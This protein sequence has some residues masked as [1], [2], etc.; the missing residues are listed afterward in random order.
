MY[1]LHDFVQHLLKG[2]LNSLAPFLLLLFF[3]SGLLG[4]I[5]WQL[6]QCL[7]YHPFLTA[8]LCIPVLELRYNKIKK[9][10]IWCCTSEGYI[11]LYSLEYPKWVCPIKLGV[12][13]RVLRLK[14][15]AIFYII[16]FHYLASWLEQSNSFSE[17]IGRVW[18]LATSSLH[19]LYQQYFFPK[20]L[21]F[22]TVVWKVT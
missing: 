14:G 12:V 18:R 13:F 4:K 5:L 7:L 22:I 10:V 21:F 20:L 1:I 9:T 19:L 15:Y 3:L 11:I 17:V 16:L 2:C 8:G 6:P